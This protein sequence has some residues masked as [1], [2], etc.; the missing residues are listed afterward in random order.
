L[1]PIIAKR[2]PFLSDYPLVD[3]AEFLPFDLHFFPP[4]E[5]KVKVKL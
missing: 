4:E 1:S 3:F 5:Q 2:I